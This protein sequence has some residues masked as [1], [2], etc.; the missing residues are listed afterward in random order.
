MRIHGI[1][2]RFPAGAAC[3]GHDPAL[4]FPQQFTPAA[5][6]TARAVAICRGC[7]IRVECL[8]YALRLDP[9]AIGIWA[10]RWLGSGKTT[11]LTPAEKAACRQ[12]ARNGTS[13]ADIARTLGLPFDRVATALRGHDGP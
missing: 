5:E 7:P 2:V 1:V 4:W 3:R 8:D 13:T 11:R 6:R 10:G 9:P 12:M